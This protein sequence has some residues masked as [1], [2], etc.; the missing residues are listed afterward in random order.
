MRARVALVQGNAIEAFNSARQSVAAAQSTPKPLDRAMFTFRSLAMAG[1][2][3]A[4]TGKR[5]QAAKAWNAALRAV[6]KAIELR[7]YEQG[8]LAALKLRVGDRA[9]A[10]QLISSLAAIGYRH[11]TYLASI[12]AAGRKP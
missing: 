3:L 7:P 6:P 1:N 11:P 10:Q 8:E 2:A 9:G 5:D 4:T 12:S